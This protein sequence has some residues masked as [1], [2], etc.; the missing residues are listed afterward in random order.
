LKRIKIGRISGA[1]GLHG[2]VKM[3]H[4]SGDEEAL[5]RLSSIVLL[6]GEVETEV[7]I[8]DLRMQ[9]RTPILKLEGIRDRNAAEALIGSEILVY[10]DE[11]RPEE[12]DA[13]LVLDLIG[14]EARIRSVDGDIAV[15][16]IKNIIDNPAHDILEIEC[17]EETRLLPF[18]DVF[19]QDVV[20]EAGYI[21]II[22]PEGWNS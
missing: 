5:K 4:D 1:Q 13:W 12:D 7:R 2:E 14:L 16:T 20:C 21:L 6:S 3:Y 15:G 9:K 17:G 19:I 22:P 11:V 8:E 18:V 10:Q